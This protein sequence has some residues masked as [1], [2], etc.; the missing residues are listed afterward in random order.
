M[1]K[2]LYHYT[3]KF[4]LASILKS[5]CLTLT[6]SNLRYHVEMYKPV[7]WLTNDANSALGL[8]LESSM[9]DKSEIKVTVKFLPHFKYWKVWSRKN[10]ID[11][12]WANGLEKGN[13]A[14]SWWI[15]EKI[16]TFDDILKIENVKTG[17]VYYQGNNAK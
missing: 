8:G 17:E 6:E 4:H 7:V 13:N 5:K 11:S 12:K 16:I 9:V 2:L 1:N 14:N 3:A 15:S 10:K